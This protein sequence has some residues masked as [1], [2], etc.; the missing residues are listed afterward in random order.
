MENT[1][2]N[3]LCIDIPDTCIQNMVY[4]LFPT[5]DYFYG[6]PDYKDTTFE[7]RTEMLSFYYLLHLLYIQPPILTRCIQQ[8]TLKCK[9][10]S[11]VYIIVREGVKRSTLKGH[12]L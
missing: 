10:N 4:G 7:H 8:L 9:F 1:K 12:D 5:S 2:K 11:L 6:S 3:G